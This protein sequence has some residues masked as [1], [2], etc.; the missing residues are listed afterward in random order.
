MATAFLATALFAVAF[1]G[2]GLAETLGLTA[3]FGLVAVVALAVAAGLLTAALVVVCGLLGAAPTTPACSA[4]S[5][6]RVATR[7]LGFMMG[8]K[9]DGGDGPT[10]VSF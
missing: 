4:N 8:G 2:A 5:A 9:L 7:I 10:G 3:A 1:F 6:A